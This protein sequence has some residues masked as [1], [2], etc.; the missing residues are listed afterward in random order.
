MQE[1]NFFIDTNIFLRVFV[2][3]DEKTFNACCDFIRIVEDGTIKA[4]SSNLVFAEVNWVLAS[5]YKFSKND[6]V[7]VLNSIAGMKNL[8]IFNDNE[9]LSALDIYS[10]HNVKFIDSLIASSAWLIEEKTKQKTII[11][12]YDKDFDKI[13]LLRYEPQ[14]ICS[15][16]KK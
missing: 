11:V 5:L 16:I 12:S 4:Y 7:Q 14:D 9:L 2:K 13:N 10:S 6:I 1:N 15:V 3:E 8:K